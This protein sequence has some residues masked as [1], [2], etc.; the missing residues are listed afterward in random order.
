M[1]FSKAWKWQ[2]FDFGL[3]FTHFKLV[4]SNLLPNF[5]V[6]LTHSFFNIM[7]SVKP[8]DQMLDV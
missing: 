3:T 6:A 7:S 5:L 1:T 4:T 2:Q 8:V